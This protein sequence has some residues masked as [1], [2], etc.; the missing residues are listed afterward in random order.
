MSQRSLF[1]NFDNFISWKKEYIGMPEFIQ[2]DLNAWK[3]FNIILEDY[4]NKVVGINFEN[5]EDFK[6]FSS[7]LNI[8][9]LTH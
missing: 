9:G 1:E 2:E 7:L 8:P 5:L 3:R 6:K 4:N